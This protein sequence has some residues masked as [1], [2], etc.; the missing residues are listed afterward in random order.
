MRSLQGRGLVAAALVLL[1][2]TA[3]AEGFQE[4]SYRRSTLISVGWEVAVPVAGLRD[5]VD[6][7]GLRGGQV[8]L[9]RGVARGLS[10]GVAAGWSWL[11]QNH[12]WK[13]VEYPD[14]VVTGPLYE[15]VRLASVR[16]T[17]HWYLTRGPLQPYLG[18]GAGGLSYETYRNIGGSVETGSGWAGVVDPQVGFLWSIGRG[19][20]VHV[21]AHFLYSW[22][23]FSGV[24]EARW[25]GIQAGLAGY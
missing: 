24:E 6:E 9:R 19:L 3:G 17:G 2:G 8:E 4:S 20:A 22:A 11:F 15:R 1:A 14:A 18:V 10:L 12:A 16:G 23:R 5:L 7:P 13:S 25:V 21:Q